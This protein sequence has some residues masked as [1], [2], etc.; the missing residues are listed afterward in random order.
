M[1]LENRLMNRIVSLCNGD[2]ARADQLIRAV[3]NYYRDQG[4]VWHLQQVIADLERLQA[5]RFQVKR[6][7]TKPAAAAAAP[8]PPPNQQRVK[9][10]TADRLLALTKGD[11]ATA[12]RLLALTRRQNPGKPEQW[13]YE[14][15]IW[16]LERGRM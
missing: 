9:R 7:G 15:V 2:R 5:E 3:E 10:A 16:D 4:T 12:D 8:P 6:A 13:V 14:K 11:R 1:D